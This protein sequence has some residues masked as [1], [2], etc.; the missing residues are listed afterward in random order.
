MTCLEHS[1]VDAGIPESHSHLSVTVLKP[2]KNVILVHSL[3]LH[4]EVDWRDVRNG[5][6]FTFSISR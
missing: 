2:F 5:I 6:S 3:V 4:Q 1:S